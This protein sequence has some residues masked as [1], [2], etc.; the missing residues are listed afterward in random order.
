MVDAPAAEALLS[1]WRPSL[2]ADGACEHKA[3]MSKHV[4]VARR[5]ELPKPTTAILSD[6]VV[7]GNSHITQIGADQLPSLKV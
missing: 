1:D 4:L 5:A 6:E 3:L 7:S 2:A